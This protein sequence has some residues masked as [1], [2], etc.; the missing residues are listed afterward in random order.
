VNLTGLGVTVPAGTMRNSRTRLW[1]KRAAAT[2]AGFAEMLFTVQGAATP[3]LPLV[4]TTIQ[5]SD[6]F[7]T[8]A[9]RVA[10]SPNGG[11]AATPEYAVGMLALDSTNLIVGVRN[12][13]GT[14]GAT[15]ATAG[16]RWR[17][18]VLVDPLVPLPVF[19]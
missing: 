17:L 11:A 8:D 16:M 19:V 14:T 3:T 10:A 15:T 12:L 6:G 2:N 13:L 18:E 4:V 9:R 5:G 7:A 1:S